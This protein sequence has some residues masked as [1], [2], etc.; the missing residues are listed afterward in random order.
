MV[1]LLSTPTAK[2]CRNVTI[3]WINAQQMYTQFAMVLLL[4]YSISTAT[5]CT[6]SSVNRAV[7][8]WLQQQYCTSSRLCLTPS[9]YWLGLVARKVHAYCFRSVLIIQVGAYGQVD[10][11]DI[12]Y[13]SRSKGLGCDSHCCSWLEVSG[14][15]LISYCSFSTQFWWVPGGWKLRVHGWSWLHVCITCELEAYSPMKEEI[16]VVCV[17][18]DGRYWSVKSVRLLSQIIIKLL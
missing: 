11:V 6:V 14:K 3:Y 13:I 4:L 12:S 8:N 7:N 15:L 16:Q 17:L 9:S 18:N 1:S 10:R 2:M 5:V